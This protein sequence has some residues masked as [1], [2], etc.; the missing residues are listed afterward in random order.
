[1][2]AIEATVAPLGRIAAL[3]E[4]M[5]TTHGGEATVFVPES[6]A[7][8]ERNAIER[9]LQARGWLWA[10]KRGAW[11]FNALCPPDAKLRVTRLA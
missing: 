5:V 7:E 6:V 8:S 11:V 10:K 2:S 4:R 9:M 1:M 3:R